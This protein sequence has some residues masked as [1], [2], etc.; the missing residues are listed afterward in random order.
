MYRQRHL[1]K[2]LRLLRNGS[3]QLNP[4]VTVKDDRPA[5]KIK[6]RK[7]RLT[8]QTQL[9]FQLELHCQMQ[10]VLKLS[11]N[12][13]KLGNLTSHLVLEPLT[14]A[15]TRLTTGAQD[16]AIML[17]ACGFCTK[18]EAVNRS[19]IPTKMDLLEDN[20]RTLGQQQPLLALTLPK[21]PRVNF[22]PMLQ[23]NLKNRTLSMTT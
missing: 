2:V 1:S 9:H 19:I 21:C 8:H 23:V 4:R 6:E 5:I 11:S 18:P 15:I 10:V 13:I 17:V 7:T 16:Q 22:E 12:I 20:P 3:P 14:L